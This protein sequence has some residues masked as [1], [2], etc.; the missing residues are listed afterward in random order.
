MM[1]E[2]RRLLES[3]QGQPFPEDVVSDPK[4]IQWLFIPVKRNSS[5]NDTD[6]LSVSDNTLPHPGWW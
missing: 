5:K 3:P 1:E 4:S 6:N 2:H